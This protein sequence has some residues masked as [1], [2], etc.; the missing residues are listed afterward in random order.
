MYM[1][2]Y[3]Y[4]LLIYKWKENTQIMKFDEEWLKNTFFW[5]IKKYTRPYQIIADR[6]KW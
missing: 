3:I 1:Y 6:T 4:K 5:E 2:I